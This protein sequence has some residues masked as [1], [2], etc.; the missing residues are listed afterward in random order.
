MIAER[1]ESKSPMAPPPATDNLFG[2][3]RQ[4]WMV[5]YNPFKNIQKLHQPMLNT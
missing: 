1:C 3:H 5:Q 4:R 2:K